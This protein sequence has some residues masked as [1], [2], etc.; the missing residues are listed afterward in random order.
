[1]ATVYKAT[2]SDITLGAEAQGATILLEGGR[3]AQ[4]VPMPGGTYRVFI[5]DRVLTAYALHHDVRQKT[6]TLSAGGF[7]F[8]VQLKDRLDQVLDTFGLGASKAAKVA[9]LKAPMPGLVQRVLVQPGQAVE[10]GTPLLVLVAMKMENMIKAT[11]PGT[12]AKINVKEG[13][14]VEKGHVLI[15]F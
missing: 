6:L 15:G 5:D 3:T 13:D 1:M 11:G 10:K 2:I 12:V 9:D 4:I 7:Q 14:A 8:E